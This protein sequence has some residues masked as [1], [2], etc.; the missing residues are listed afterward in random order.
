MAWAWKQP[1]PS[2]RKLVLLAIADHADDQGICWPSQNGIARKCGMSRVSVWRNV[3]DLVSSG[4]IKSEPRT[5]RG[6]KAS[7]VYQ[8]CID[9]TIGV[10]DVNLCNNDITSTQQPVISLTQQL[11]PSIEPSIPIY[12]NKPEWYATLEDIP[13]CNVSLEDAQA[14]LIKKQISE[15]HAENV[16]LALLSKWNPKK[17]KNVYATFRNWCMMPPLGGVNHVNGTGTKKGEGHGSSGQE[18]EKRA[19]F[20]SWLHRT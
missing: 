1:I 19:A 6:L 4:H 17:W 18:K 2:H 5:A 10:T 8:C 7:N 20:R 15:T 9:D 12:T 11:K 13:G 16:A 14:W 3:R